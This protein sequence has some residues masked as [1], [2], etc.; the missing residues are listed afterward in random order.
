MPLAQFVCVGAYRF[1]VLCSYQSS[2]NRPNSLPVLFLHGF[3]GSAEDW[4]PVMEV[5]GDACS[6]TSGYFGHEAEHHEA[7]CHEAEHPVAIAIDLPG[8][9]YTE[10]IGDDGFYTMPAVA[11]GIV[12]MLNTLQIC[13]CGLVGYSMGGRLALYLMIHYPERF[14]RV[15]T[16]S[17]SP[18]LKTDGDRHARRI[19]DEALAHRIE[20]TDFSAFLR[21]WYQQPLFASLHH[22]PDFPAL[23]ERRSCNSPQHLGRSLRYMGTGQQ[24]SLWAAL[25]ANTTPLLVMVGEQDDKYR[26][27][28]AEMGD[29]HP[30]CRVLIVPTCGHTLHVE[31]PDF[32]IQ[33]LQQFFSR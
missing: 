7:E 15:V 18:G 16:V 2:V 23:L 29:R 10:V 1:H 26:R 11:E 19:H 14:M 27:I 30:Q 31:Q 6:A 25:D 13:Q 20:T 28:A 4:R 33:Q 32:F 22:H 12:D 3:M 24:P 17:A 8:H 9:G 5:W 21:R